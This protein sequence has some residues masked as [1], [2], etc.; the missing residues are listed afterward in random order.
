MM[1]AVRELLDIA[2][3]Q[4]GTRESPA[5]SNT[6]KYNTA[7]YGRPVYDGLWGTTFPWCVVFCWW[8][9]REAG[10]SSLFYG[11]G[12]TASCTELRDWAKRSGRWVTG[13]YRPGDVVI[14]DWH[15]DGRPDHCGIVET[16]GGSSVVA[17][18]G[19]TGIG[20]DS[21]GGEVMRRTRALGDIQG[22]Y[23]PAYEEDDMD[24]EALTD[25]QLVR[26]A[27]R[28]QA[29]LAD[30][31]VGATLRPELA[32]AMAAGITDGS[33]PNAFCTR[34]QAAVMVMRG[35]SR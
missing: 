13:D 30:Q 23:R 27:E 21:N 31:G 35:T 32:A 33:S 11:G 8:C 24:I 12:K 3:A 26:L 7:Y 5:G 22:A 19:N 14:Y 25:E 9:F 17:I 2:R 16:A 28:M 34:A 20:N 18:E 15:D 1:A 6:V 4:L 29:A 10:A